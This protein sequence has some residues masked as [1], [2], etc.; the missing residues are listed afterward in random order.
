MITIKYRLSH[1]ATPVRRG[2]STN[3]PF[4]MVNNNQD[5]FMAT[6]SSTDRVREAASAAGLSIEPKTAR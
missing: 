3:K 5:L 2:S 6:V 1:L 4:N